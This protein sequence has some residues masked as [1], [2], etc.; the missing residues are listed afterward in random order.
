MN[1]IAKF[2]QFKN[3]L[4]YPKTL[5][6][7][8]LRFVSEKHQESPKNIDPKIEQSFSNQSSKKPN[9]NNFSS[10]FKKVNRI[11]TKPLTKEE[12]FLMDKRKEANLPTSDKSLNK[13]IITRELCADFFMIT[14]KTISYLNTKAQ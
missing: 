14:V 5:V 2:C 1:R 8:P 11:F 10:D 12:A 3:T 9:I 13:K 6:S 4:I 7:I